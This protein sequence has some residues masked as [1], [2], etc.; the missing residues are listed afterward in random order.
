MAPYCPRGVAGVAL[1]A[2]HGFE[3]I[4]AVA[5][6]LLGWFD[7]GLCSARQ[8]ILVPISR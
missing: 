4:T 8:A 7:C 5:L 2:N 6:A 3:E 1:Q